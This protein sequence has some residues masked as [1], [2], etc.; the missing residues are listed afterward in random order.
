MTEGIRPLRVAGDIKSLLATLLA[1]LA[2][3]RLRQ[4]VVTRVEVPADLAV[5][6]VY[7]RSLGGAAAGVDELALVRGLR[8]AGPRLRKAMARR[9][10]LRRVPELRFE[11][12]RGVD[13]A[14]RVEAL[15][16]EIAHERGD[17]PDESS[18]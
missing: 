17:E 9:L 3:E 6:W 11:Y 13:A 4:L 16:Q 18:D 5:A 1:Q 7:V 14:D 10:R 8:R 15:L 12:D 2:D